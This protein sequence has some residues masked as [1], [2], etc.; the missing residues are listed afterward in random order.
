VTNIHGI[1][2]LTWLLPTATLTF[3]GYLSYAI[4]GALVLELPVWLILIPSLPA[5]VLTW[6]ALIVAF[7]DVSRRPKTQISEEA[8]M[9]WLLML[10]LLNIL[11]VLPYWL[12]VI[13]RQPRLAG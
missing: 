12:I 7:V 10:A 2:G 8:R 4:V 11:A 9:V 1:S 3:I 13:R 6:L 5:V